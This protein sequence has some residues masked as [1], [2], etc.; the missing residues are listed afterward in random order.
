MCVLAFHCLLLWA[1]TQVGS[2]RHA[3]VAAAAVPLAV[4]LLTLDGPTPQ[5]QASEGLSSPHKPWPTA[6]LQHWPNRDVPATLTAVWPSPTVATGNDGSPAHTPEP[7]V[8]SAATAANNPTPVATTPAAAPPLVSRQDRP[9]HQPPGGLRYLLEPAV[10]VPKLS[11]RAHESGT[12]LLHVVVDVQGQPRSVSLRQSS[13]Y[14]RLDE[15][16][17]AAMR[18][19]RFVPC[20]EGGKAVECEADAPIVFELEP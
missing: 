13:G 10:V 20:T 4:R 16:A 1:L 3:S 9:L 12:V 17:L 7:A 2:A 14:A 11:R 18:S 5:A 6:A 19:A 15:Q 8:P